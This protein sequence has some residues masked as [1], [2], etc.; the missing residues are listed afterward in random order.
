MRHVGRCDHH[1]DS[2]VAERLLQASTYARAHQRRLIDGPVRLYQ[3]VDVTALGVI[4]R[5]RAKQSHG[6]LGS[7]HR[8]NR[9][10]NGAACGEAQAHGQSVGRAFCSAGR[11]GQ[12]PRCLG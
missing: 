8:P 1:V 3:K 6:G 11:L 9:V 12:E 2:L 4:I 10:T 7:D 5:A